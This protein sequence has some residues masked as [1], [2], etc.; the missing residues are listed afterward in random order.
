MKNRYAFFTGVAIGGNLAR[1]DTGAIV[2]LVAC[3]IWTLLVSR[4]EFTNA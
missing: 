4:D 1:N 2:A 3:F